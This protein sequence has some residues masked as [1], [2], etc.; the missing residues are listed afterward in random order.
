MNWGLFFSTFL[1]IFLA[2][3]GDKTQ[4]AVM[5]QSAASSS[6][7]T[8][9]AAG[10][11]ALTASTAIGVLA[12]DLLRRFIP[13]D[14]WIKCAGGALFLVFGAWM[15]FEAFMPQFRADKSGQETAQSEDWTDRPIISWLERFEDGFSEMYERMETRSLLVEERALFRRLKEEERWHHESMLCAMTGEAAKSFHFTERIIKR[16]PPLSD[17]QYNKSTPTADGKEGYL[18]A[19]KKERAMAHLYQVLAES[20]THRSLRETF[21]AL[22]VVEENHAKRLTDHL[23]ASI[24]PHP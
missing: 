17:L 23:R 20:T 6:K 3:L 13:D 16:L 21:D 4:L 24:T 15:L 9:F 22:R 1:L 5:S 2:E 7:W 11:L 10:A 8:I 18:F 14:R 12:G 19:I